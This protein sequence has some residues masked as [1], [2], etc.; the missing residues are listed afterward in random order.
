AAKSDI[1]IINGGMLRDDLPEGD[2][3]HRNIMALFPFGNTLRIAEIK[4]ATIREM[5]EHSVEYYPASFGGFMN[6]SGMTFSYDPSKP[7]KHRVEEIFIG[8]TPLDEDKIYTIALVDFHTSGGDDYGMLTG[9]NIVG[10]LGT[11]EEIFTDYLNQVGMKD[12]A[13]GRITRLKEVPVP[14]EE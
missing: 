2:V 14:D 5:L 6:V 13:V 12:Y 4:G 1:A 8:G 11:V 7:A 3:K 10:E 9:L